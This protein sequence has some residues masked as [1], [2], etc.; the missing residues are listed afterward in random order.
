MPPVFYLTPAKLTVSYGSNTT[1]SCSVS[2]FPAPISLA[3][4]HRHHDDHRSQTAIPE[5]IVRRAPTDS[6]M[7]HSW[8]VSFQ[9]TPV[10]ESDGGYYQCVA[11]YAREP[12]WNT[13]I[14]V[15]VNSVFVD[16]STDAGNEPPLPPSTAASSAPWIASGVITGCVLVAMATYMFVELSKRKR[17]R[18]LS[19][20]LTGKEYQYCVNT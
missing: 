2:S 6:S 7:L 8:T 19:V 18:S 10:D 12:R 1:M 11:T 4:S 20:A 9:L 5:L 3:W 13:T 17:D 16:F 14:T 15:S